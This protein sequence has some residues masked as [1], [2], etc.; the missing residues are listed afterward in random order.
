MPG[1]LADVT[2]LA[3]LGLLFGVGMTALAD[4]FGWGYLIVL[5]IIVWAL[6]HTVN[7]AVDRWRDQP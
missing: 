7:R 3:V 4:D 2:A 6:L 5:P 1:R